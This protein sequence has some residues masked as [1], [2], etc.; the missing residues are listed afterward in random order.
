MSVRVL[1]LSPRQTRVDFERTGASLV[2][3]WGLDARGIN[4]ETYNPADPIPNLREYDAVLAWPYGLKYKGFLA[5]CKAFERVCIEYGVPVVNSLQ[6]FNIRHS[7]GLYCWKQEGIPCADYQHISCFKDIKLD[8]PLILRTDGVHR[9]RNVY[10]VSN[11][12]EARNVLENGYSDPSYPPV[13]LAIQY[14]DTQSPD[15]YYRKWRSHV[16]GDKVIPRQLT[17]SRE[18]VVHLDSAVF[19]QQAAEEDRRFVEEGE[20]RADLV[21]RAAR[22]LDADIVALDYSRLRDGSYIFWEGNR[23]Y[24]LSVGGG[25]WE[26]FS[27]STNRTDEQLMNSLL[28][29]G[30]AIADL[31]LNAAST[32]TRPG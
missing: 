4:W 19:D 32:A 8:Y 20:P 12:K 21:I 6:H 10:L 7:Y 22:A 14:I 17:L 18:W 31:L 3:A 30:E 28:V 23:N 29:I 2:L 27:R 15:G 24:D 11:P 9:G 1:V 26:Q 16:V 5:N 25:M 13:D